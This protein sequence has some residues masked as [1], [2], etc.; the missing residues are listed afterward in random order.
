MVEELMDEG[1]ELH[2]FLFCQREKST[3]SV[4][5]CASTTLRYTAVNWYL[6]DPDRQRA[7]EAHFEGIALSL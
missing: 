2:A 1:V 6:Y 4:R 5:L 7:Q 3:R